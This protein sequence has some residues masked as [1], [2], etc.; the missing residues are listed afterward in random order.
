MKMRHHQRKDPQSQAR[1]RVLD[2][3]SH[4]QW[5]LAKDRGELRQGRF[6][7]RGGPHKDKRD[8]RSRGWD[9]EE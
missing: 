5:K 6:M 4:A 8:N 9:D 1:H 7:A 3:V 2:S